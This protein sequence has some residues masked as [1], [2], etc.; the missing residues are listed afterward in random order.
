MVS[1]FIKFL[2]TINI[3]FLKYEGNWLRDFHRFEQVKRNDPSS[4]TLNGDVKQCDE[5]LPDYGKCSCQ[6]L[7]CNGEQRCQHTTAHR[8]M[9]FHLSCELQKPLGEIDLDDATF[10]GKDADCACRAQV[11]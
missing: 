11:L 4:I 3:S 1:G 6:G 8:G 7:L 9:K 2:K 5:E 10:G